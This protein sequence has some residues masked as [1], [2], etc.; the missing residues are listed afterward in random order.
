MTQNKIELYF[1][2]RNIGGWLRVL[3]MA[4]YG[5]DELRD[6]ELLDEQER[7]YEK[8]QELYYFKNIIPEAKMQ[9]FEFIREIKKERPD[10]IIEFNHQ[11]VKEL[12]EK[13]TEII[14]NYEN[15]IWRG[16]TIWLAEIVKELNNPEKILKEIKKLQTEIDFLRNKTIDENQITESDIVRAKE[17][18]FDNLIEVNKSGFAYCPFHN[19]QVP[20]FYIKNNFG[21]CF[22]CGKAVDTIQFLI[23]T[24]GFNFV[25]AINK[26]K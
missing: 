21:Y 1:N 18:P 14:S 2:I 15:S 16:N 20:S 6:F 11:K 22:G 26:L 5:E 13:A 4:G 12:M 17:Y 19:E 23:D 3:E 24:K 25:E 7:G 8:D 10:E 9:E